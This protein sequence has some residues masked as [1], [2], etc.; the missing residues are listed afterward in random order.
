MYHVERFIYYDQYIIFYSIYNITKN[1]GNKKMQSGFYRVDID[2]NKL[3]NGFFALRYRYSIDGKRATI[4]RTSLDEL[5]K[6][7]LENDLPW[8]VTDQEKAAKTRAFDQDFRKVK[9][10]KQYFYDNEEIQKIRDEYQEKISPI[11][12]E[13]RDKISKVLKKCRD[14]NYQQRMA[15]IRKFVNDMNDENFYKK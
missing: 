8:K 14:K 9:K 4:S 2:N 6:T 3:S 1:G 13:Y 11:R 7:I 12:D 15:L 10:R 5:E